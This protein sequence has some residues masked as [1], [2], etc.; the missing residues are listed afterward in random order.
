MSCEYGHPLPWGRGIQGTIKRFSLGWLSMLLV[1]HVKY[2]NK[3]IKLS[4]SPIGGKVKV[5][6]N[7]T[8]NLRMV[9]IVAYPLTAALH[10]V[11]TNGFIFARGRP[12]TRSWPPVSPP[13]SS[14]MS[15][16]HLRVRAGVKGIV[17]WKKQY[18]KNQIYSLKPKNLKIK[19]P[20]WCNK[21]HIDKWE[22]RK[23]QEWIMFI[24]PLS[25]FV[26]FLNVLTLYLHQEI[27]MINF[28]LIQSS[29][30]LYMSFQCNANT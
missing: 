29:I 7:K 23:F 10:V 5:M 4:T 17:I 3:H 2:C 22:V 8:H 15:V 18:N 19:V 14:A 30:L 13:S 11:H 12:R 6:N 16:A 28:P 20:L 24:F 9:C 1:T 27:L 25:L 26:M 21:F